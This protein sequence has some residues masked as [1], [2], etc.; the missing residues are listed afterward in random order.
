MT[1]ALI[2]ALKARLAEV[3]QGREKISE[4][5]KRLEVLAGALS[6]E[7]LHLR[8]LIERHDTRAALEDEQRGPQ[9]ALGSAQSETQPS[10]LDALPQSG[11]VA[12]PT[13]VAEPAGNRWLLVAEDVLERAEPRRLSG[14]SSGTGCWRRT[15]Q[16]CRR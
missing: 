9:L 7:S 1:E 11:T 14:S 15:A 3:E 8:A 4:E 2:G 16:W 5:L 10:R 12:A 13:A 6:D